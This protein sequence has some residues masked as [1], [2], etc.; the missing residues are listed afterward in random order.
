MNERIWPE[1]L[2]VRPAHEE[3]APCILL[4]HGLGASKEDL[5]PLADYMDPEKHFRW[6]FPDAPEK[7]VTLNAGRKMRA[8]YDIY[9]LSRD[10]GEDAAGM[11]GMGQRLALL[12]DQERQ[13]ADHHPLIL[14]GFSQGGAMS[15]YLALHQG[16]PLAAVLAMSAYLPLRQDLPKAIRNIPIF[17]GHGRSD[18]VLPLA[19]METAREILESLGCVLSTHAY[20]MD[21]SICAEELGDARQFVD[22]IIMQGNR[23]LS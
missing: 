23:A 19:Y 5:A 11:Q 7:A 3:T 14:G 12:L 4:L 8:W 13:R 21:H 6:V 20:P 2:W 16:Y 18:P 15:L 1:G 22:S 17:W 10:S 9:G